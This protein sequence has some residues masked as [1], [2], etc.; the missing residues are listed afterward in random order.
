M[1]K[2]IVCP[3]CEGEGYIGTLGSYTVA[4]FEES[5]E[6]FETYSE[7]HN[8]SKVPCPAC[9]ARRVITR[10]E[11]KAHE[12]RLIDEATQRAEMRMYG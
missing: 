6:S 1:S 7:L 5:F 3:H 8:A 11:L 10:Q 4:E 9:H 2:Y 12:A